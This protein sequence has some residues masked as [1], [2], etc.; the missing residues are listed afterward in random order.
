MKKMYLVLSAAVVI[1][2]MSYAAWRLTTGSNR[3]ADDKE[4]DNAGHQ[5]A[6]DTPTLADGQIVILPPSNEESEVTVPDP[7]VGTFTIPPDAPAT[8]GTP[9]ATPTFVVPPSLQ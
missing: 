8:S 7:S 3:S 2:L 5:A 4:Q 1:A 6:S 9:A